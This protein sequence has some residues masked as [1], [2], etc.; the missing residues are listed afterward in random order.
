MRPL[1]AIVGL[2][3]VGA[4][5]WLALSPL[6]VAAL[7]H[8]PSA[9]SSQMINLR[10]SWGGAVAGL[11]AFVAWLPALRPWRRFALG[12][13]LWTMAGIGA[14]RAY[15][16]VVDGH[17]DRMQWIWLSAEAAIVAA[18]ASFLLRKRAAD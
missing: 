17:P 16:F 11:G 5:V 14:A 8:R 18:C 13:L 3:V 12:L 9:T 1:R 4:G 10:A 15:G 7:L 2:L 6:A